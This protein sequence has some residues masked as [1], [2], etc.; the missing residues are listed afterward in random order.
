MYH[1]TFIENWE[2]SYLYQTVGAWY[3]E[4]SRHGML[5]K[6]LGSRTLSQRAE[7]QCKG[8]FGG[9]DL[10]KLNRLNFVSAEQKFSP[11]PQA[12]STK[13]PFS[14]ETSQPSQSQQHPTPC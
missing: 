6:A 8:Y 12:P 13:V 10:M 2:R 1:R 9:F 4:D 5:R 11:P 3:G 7:S 14:K